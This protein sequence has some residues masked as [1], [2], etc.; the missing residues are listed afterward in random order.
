MKFA[1]T[2]SSLSDFLTHGMMCA[3]KFGGIIKA[4]YRR[5][6]ASY[7]CRIYHR[8]TSQRITLYVGVGLGGG[9]RHCYHVIMTTE[10]ELNSESS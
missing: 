5:C 4:H 8:R 1:G 6:I 7:S 10:P 9:L 3:S 2:Y